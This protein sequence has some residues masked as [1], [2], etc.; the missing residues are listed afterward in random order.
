MDG[1][2]LSASVR[3]VI[4]V[5]L[6]RIRTARISFGLKRAGYHGDFLWDHVIVDA[7]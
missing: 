4:I 5:T 7:S 2:L 3:H 1:T 6:F